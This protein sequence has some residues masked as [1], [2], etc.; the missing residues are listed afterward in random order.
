VGGRRRSR[1]RGARCRGVRVVMAARGLRGWS[2]IAVA[3]VVLAM[4]FVTVL[5]VALWHLCLRLRK[6]TSSS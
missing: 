2:V 1:G 6:A 4:A 5:E 3:I